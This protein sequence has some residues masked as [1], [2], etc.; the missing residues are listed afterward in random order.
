MTRGKHLRKVC[1]LCEVCAVSIPLD[2]DNR[3]AGTRKEG[4][5]R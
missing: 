5:G 1:V 4:D 3:K 2:A